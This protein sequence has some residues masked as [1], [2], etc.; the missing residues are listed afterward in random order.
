MENAKK[1]PPTVFFPT[2]GVR[3]YPGTLLCQRVLAEG[4]IKSSD[5]LM[6][7]VYYISD[8]VNPDEIKQEA[9]KTGRKWVFMDEDLGPGMKRMRSKGIKGPLW[10]YL[11]Q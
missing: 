4:L 11:V 9:Q 8:Q 1:I 7:S 3:I 2:M 10:E 5:D 6:D